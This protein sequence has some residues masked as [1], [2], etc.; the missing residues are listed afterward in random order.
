MHSVHVCLLA[1]ETEREPQAPVVIVFALLAF[2][3]SVL[4]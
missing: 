4:P 1:A 2:G 3:V